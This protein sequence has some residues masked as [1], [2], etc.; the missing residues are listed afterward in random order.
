MGRRHMLPARFAKSEIL[1]NPVASHVIPLLNLVPS[2]VAASF[3]V[4]GLTAV[5]GPVI[6]HLLNR[7]RYRVVHGT[8]RS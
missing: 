8:H 4:A 3:A 2:F 5:A 7:R 1:P 6:I